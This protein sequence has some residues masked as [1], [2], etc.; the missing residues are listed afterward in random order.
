MKQFEADELANS[1]LTR[2]RKRKCEELEF[3]LVNY[4]KLRQK[5]HQQD[6]IGLS[7]LMMKTKLMLW[8]KE[9]ESQDIKYKQFKAS[10]SFISSVLAAHNLV[11]VNLHGEAGDMNPEEKAKVLLQ[12]RRKL[13]ADIDKYGLTPSQI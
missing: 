10:S 3:K 9:S 2:L 1:S 4:I 7:W 8:A 13:N 12:F 11:G 5:R 6:N